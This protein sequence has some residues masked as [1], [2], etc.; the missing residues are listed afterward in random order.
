MVKITGTITGESDK[1]F[2][3]KIES[4]EQNQLNGETMWF[5]KSRVRICDPKITIEVE[6][7]LY[8][9]KVKVVSQSK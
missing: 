4:D 2:Y 8:D 7:W 3:L 9:E 1:A 6:E 5:P